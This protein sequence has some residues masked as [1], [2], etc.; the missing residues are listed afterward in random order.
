[1]GKEVDVYIYTELKALFGGADLS[2]EDSIDGSAEKSES[3]VEST[4]GEI[5]SFDEVVALLNSIFSRQGVSVR[6]ISDTLDCFLSEL[7]ANSPQ[8][9]FLTSYLC[10][11]AVQNAVLKKFNAV[12]GAQYVDLQSLANAIGNNVSDAN[13]IFLSLRICDPAVGCGEFLDVMLDE[14]IAVKSSLGLLVD[15]DGNPLYQ[16]KFISVEGGLVVF[17]KK[18]LRHVA[19]DGCN[20]ESVNIQDIICEEKS[21]LIKNCLFGVDCDPYVVLISKLRLWLHIVKTFNGRRIKSLHIL[22]GNII[23]GDALV[24]RFS[25]KDDLLE[26]LKRINYN[27]VDY[28]RLAENL[29]TN[30]DPD[31]RYY[32]AETIGLIR[33]RLVEGIGWY[34]K[35]S[36]ELL[37]LRRELSEALAPSLFPLDETEKQTHYD[38]VSLLQAK[39]KK[40]E[41]QLYAYRF[42]QAFNKAIEWRY[43]FPE[44]LDEKG[45]FLGF[46][47]MVGALPDM[48]IDD[49]GD[50]YNVYKRMNFTSLKR[51]GY[52][53]DLFCELTNRLLVQGGY[54]SYF[55]PCRCI[56]EISNLCDYLAANM[57][58]LRLVLFEEAALKDNC[59]LIIQKD[60][61][62]RRVIKCVIESSYNPKAINI[63]E[64]IWKFS[65]TVPWLV[66]KKVKIPYS[67]LITDEEIYENIKYKI[68]H[69]GMNLRSWDIS[70]H[71]G[72]LTGCD[73]AFIISASEREELIF[74]D[75]KNSDFIKPLLSSDCIKRYKNETPEK[76]ILFLPWHFPLEFDASIT[77]ASDR[78]E[79]R[80]QVQYP[81]I[82]AHLM[83]YKD[84][85]YS[86]NNEVGVLFEWYVLQSLDMKDNRNY[87]AEQKIVWQR[88]ASDCRFGIDYGGC[89]VLDNACYMV[90]QHL[91]FILGVLNSKMGRYMLTDS[92]RLSAKNSQLSV[93]AVESMLV[94]PPSGDMESDM[95]TLVNRLI[96]ENTMTDEERYEI[97]A[98]IDELVYEL[99][100]LTDDERAFVDAAVI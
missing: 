98:R 19:L 78:A 96:T 10:R 58:P 85:L 7:N 81:D 63:E 36:E 24:S 84:T 35:D 26:A 28:K 75:P 67:S 17:D 68:I 92:G 29:K 49:L 11:Q 48:S 70:V 43:V 61:N 71:S 41:Q 5:P 15:R 54:A 87:F 18:G 37:R 16:Y 45:K 95:I 27:V 32:I 90:G 62:R 57:N 55:L 14:M 50:K 47:A 77:S 83:K 91:K 94:P 25:L 79:Q 23:C 6:A 3:V 69:A 31:E 59:A 66:E 44:L 100:E 20:A 65:E 8:T 51:S 42:H 2:A 93:F 9:Y 64:Y 86:R 33:N 1:M 13:R 40:H 34:S 76:W 46:D 73:E 21:A 22:E 82:Y 88:D 72:I 74:S 4:D 89:I 12:L 80:F 60:I 52:V 97:D 53:A 38:K 30:E 39:I 56:Y 99:Y